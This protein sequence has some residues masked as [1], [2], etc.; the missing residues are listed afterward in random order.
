MAGD[1]GPLKV[2][3]R[4]YNFRCVSLAPVTPANDT[5]KPKKPEPKPP[6]VA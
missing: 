2:A 6:T 4:G 1:C 5:A 3:L